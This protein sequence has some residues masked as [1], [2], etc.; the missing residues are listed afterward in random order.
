MNGDG[1]PQKAFARKVDMARPG[2]HPDILRYR[3]SN[4]L[5]P[6]V[7]QVSHQTETNDLQRA[8]HCID[9]CTHDNGAG[10]KLNI[11]YSSATHGLFVAACCTP[12]C[13]PLWH[14]CDAHDNSMQIN[15]Q[16]QITTLLQQ[17][18]SLM[19]VTVGV[20]EF[21]SDCGVNGHIC[22]YCVQ[23]DT[24]RTPAPQVSLKSQD[25]LSRSYHS[26]RHECNVNRARAEGDTEVHFYHGEHLIHAT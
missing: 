9:Q 6:D 17:K 3:Y 14:C 13:P 16:Q 2:D 1:S 15:R 25:A 8:Q 22:A 7:Y 24:R 26:A 12:A 10:V 19:C 4:G 18:V 5:C 11:P 21:A 23:F 20:T